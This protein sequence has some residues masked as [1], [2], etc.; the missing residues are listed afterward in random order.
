MNR[1]AP[2]SGNSPGP[3]IQLAEQANHALI[4]ASRRSANTERGGLLIGFREG[5][6]IVVE[7]ILDVPDVAAG[8]TAY[9]RR[10]GPAQT[11]LDAYFARPGADD[12]I[13]YVGEWHTH[14]S[15]GGPSRVDQTAMRTMVRSNR[16]SIALVVAALG[17]D[18]R[19]VQL[20]GLISASSALWARMAGR[21]IKATLL[22]T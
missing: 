15:P 7:D 4:A 6:D 16:H 2:A 20:H 21:W 3:R 11:V 18:E 22:T 17:D 10:E 12:H 8:R 13:G 5:D 19:S 14:P 1:H 9:L